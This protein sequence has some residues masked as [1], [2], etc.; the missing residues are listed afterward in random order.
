MKMHTVFKEWS[1]W[2]LALIFG[3]VLVFGFRVLAFH[4]A[5]GGKLCVPKRATGKML[6]AQNVLP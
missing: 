5:P 1:D 6:E 3:S 2:W 4:A